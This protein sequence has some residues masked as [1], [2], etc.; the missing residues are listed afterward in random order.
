MTLAEQTQGSDKDKTP[1]EEMEIKMQLEIMLWV[2]LF[3]ATSQKAQRK[4]DRWADREKEGKEA[5]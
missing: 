1:H 2:C 5:F 3:V 4:K